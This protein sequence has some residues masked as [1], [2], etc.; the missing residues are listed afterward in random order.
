MGDLPI[1]DYVSEKWGGQPHYASAMVLLGEDDL[2]IWLWGPVGR[3]IYRGD[4]A[5]FVTEHDVITVIP[6]DAWWA[7]AWWLGHPELELYVNIN[8]PAEISDERIAYTDLDLDVVRRT[9]GV[10]EVV[11]RHEFDLHRVR[12]GY[13]D[14]VVEAA[15]AA[16]EQAQRLVMERVPPFDGLAAAR[17]TERARRIT[18]PRLR[19]TLR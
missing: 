10:C 15:E 19:S 6:R 2:G 1:V 18:P 4:V 14:D 3:T 7:P 12:Y 5:L 9:D 17:W 13:P 8:T 11:D 16:A